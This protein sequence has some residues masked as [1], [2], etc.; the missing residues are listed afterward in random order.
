MSSEPPPDETATTK[1]GFF[2]RRLSAIKS[3]VGD[4]V[5]LKPS[6]GELDDLMEGLHGDSALLEKRCALQAKGLSSFIIGDLNAEEEPSNKPRIR[7]AKKTFEEVT[8]SLNTGFYTSEYDPVPN[9]LLEASDWNFNQDSEV[10]EGLFMSTIETRDHER[11]LISIE[12]N[13]LIQK[14][15]PE[16]MVCMKDVNDIDNNL[17][18][19][20]LIISNGRRKLEFAKGAL[21]G[22]L[23]IIQ[24]Q[25][26]RERIVQV[27]Q[28]LKSLKNLTDLSKSMRDS[29][30]TDDYMSAAQCACHVLDSLRNAVYQ[31]FNCV[32]SISHCTG[33]LLPIIRRKVDKA[34]L[35]LCGRKYVAQE[36]EQIVK[37]YMLLDHMADS[38]Q[39]NISYVGNEADAMV[40]ASLIDESEALLGDGY[41]CLDGLASRIYRYQ[42]ADLKTCVHT[43]VLEFVC[44][45]QHKKQQTAI[46]LNSTAPVGDDV[47]D[48]TDCSTEEL[49]EKLPADMI[50]ACV[51]RA[52]EFLLDVVHTHYSITQW[53]LTPFDP[54]NTDTHYAHRCPNNLGTLNEELDSE[55]DD[56]E[57]DEEEEE[58]EVDG[59]EEEEETL[60]KP[61]S[62][63]K[64]GSESESHITE[65]AIKAEGVHTVLSEESNA[66]T[67]ESLDLSSL[68]AQSLTDSNST[69]PTP[70]PTPSIKSPSDKNGKVSLKKIGEKTK[71][72]VTNLLSNS[73]TAAKSATKAVSS[74]V[75]FA[76]NMQKQLLGMVTSSSS[77]VIQL[78]NNTTV[79]DVNQSVQSGIATAYKVVAKTE[80]EIYETITNIPTRIRGEGGSIDKGGNKIDNND[81]VQNEENIAN[82]KDLL[83]SNPF[84]DRDHP[85]VVIERL[86]RLERL[87]KARL[88]V[89]YQQLCTYRVKLW[90]QIIHYLCSM[91]L[92]IQFT[93]SISLDDYLCINACME[94]VIKVGKSFCGSQ[95]KELI[96]IMKEKTIEYFTYLHQNSF[97]MFRLMIE[98][99]SWAN[100]P[101][102]LSDVGGILGMIHM[103]IARNQL[104][105]CNTIFHKYSR[106][107]KLESGE[108]TDDILMTFAEYGNP[109]SNR[110]SLHVDNE[111]VTET[112]RDTAPVD[113][114]PQVKAMS[115]WDDILLGS[116][117]ELTPVKASKAKKSYIMTQ[118]ALNG[119]AKYIG[120][121]MYMMHIVPVVT[122]DAYHG[123]I[124]MIEYYIAAVFVGLVPTEER[125]KL[126]NKPTKLNSPPP[127]HI[128]TYEA[129]QDCMSRVL[130]TAVQII[131]KK[132]ASNDT[133]MRNIAKNMSDSSESLH[134]QSIKISN[135]LNKSSVIEEIEQ[136]GSDYDTNSCRMFA[137][138][139]RIVAAESCYFIGEV[140]FE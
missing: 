15:Y 70:T 10:V 58:D 2:T 35:R 126:L 22:D 21:H 82:D 1:P 115:F 52:A 64:G 14:N 24:L 71:K 59:E 105:K 57:G 133:D 37:T 113:T 109:L 122:V 114:V 130:G 39:L 41:G 121:Y 129:L 89:G 16:L 134:V 81:N 31:Q 44:A 90:E 48:L 60:N 123:L 79:A 11:N 66:P 63:T 56:S 98:A 75:K 29:I 93:A 54:R 51:L 117:K 108:I 110:T 127:E 119:I 74:Q 77:S 49:V 138:N 13:N 20:N 73:S 19:T 12:L 116:S 132:S 128:R 91:L 84:F 67:E 50:G 72:G 38:L 4:V 111:G 27:Q 120:T 94:T 5:G 139:E 76:W 83:E 104:Q 3:S 46:E 32:R 118:S 101:I 112:D 124:Q 68:V 17:Q 40:S 106:T 96:D 45:A 140:Y 6:D 99:E 25:K 88:V 107:M 9:Q 7:K 23:K 28:T 61:P 42:Q 47:F 86:R 103:N 131:S 30:V 62:E 33:N 65:S 43:A 78:I 135:L 34:L 8:E 53:H 125:I 85:D 95:S 102:E 80:Q 26:K 55:A 18:I 92:S 136:S 36:Y 69:T 137:M 97:Q 87:S 100:V